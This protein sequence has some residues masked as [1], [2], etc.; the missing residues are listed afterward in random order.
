MKPDIT[1]LLTCMGGDLAP[2]FLISL[3]ESERYNVTTIAVDGNPRAIGRYF[4]RHFEVV[5]MGAADNYI[6]SIL[7]IVEKYAVEL[8]MAGS[9]GEALAMSLAREE[10]SRLD[11]QI[12]CP[13]ATVLQNLNNKALTYEKLQE[14]GMICAE[15]YQACG[16]IELDEA[17]KEIYDGYGEAV[18]KPLPILGL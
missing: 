5:P 16:T 7:A 15:W 10:F 6:E 8:V 17:I 13:D 9:D 4:A 14:A 2:E 11:C 3:N 1:V 18:L 12:A